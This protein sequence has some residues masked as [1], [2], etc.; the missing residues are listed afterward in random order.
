MEYGIDKREDMTHSA[1]TLSLGEI[2]GYVTRMSHG[3][4]WKWKSMQCPQGGQCFFFFVVTEYCNPPPLPPRRRV[5]ALTAASC[6]PASCPLGHVADSP[7][8]LAQPL[9]LLSR[10]LS[11]SQQ[12]SMHS[13]IS[14]YHHFP[15]M[16]R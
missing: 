14:P 9:S 13:L 16:L 11:S 1:L 12:V 2:T 15:P 5:S 7:S 6:R 8:S 3:T 4:G 10:K